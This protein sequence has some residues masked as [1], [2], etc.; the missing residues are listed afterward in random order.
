LSVRTFGKDKL[1]ISAVLSILANGLKLPPLLIFMEKQE[2]QK[3]I[4]YK[5]IYIVL[6]EKFI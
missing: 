3:N 6:T 4:N 5:R 1:R 2:G